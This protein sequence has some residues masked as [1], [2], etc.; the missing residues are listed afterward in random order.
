MTTVHKLIYFIYDYSHGKSI[1]LNLVFTL[2]G[3]H[4]QS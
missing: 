3:L 1:A 4:I 2:Y